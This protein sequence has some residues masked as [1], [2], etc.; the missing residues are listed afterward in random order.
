M[1]MNKK[2]LLT[3]R[4]LTNI[5][6]RDHRNDRDI[7]TF[8]SPLKVP[9]QSTFTPVPENYQLVWPHLDFYINRILTEYSL[10]VAGFSARRV[11]EL[12]SHDHL[13][14]SLL[15]FIAEHYFIVWIDHGLFTHAPVE[16][17]LSFF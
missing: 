3:L 13:V 11:G 10:F 17:C 12:H 9:L 6:T 5:D 8:S 7:T 15:L 2:D 4:V 14:S 1:K 16:W